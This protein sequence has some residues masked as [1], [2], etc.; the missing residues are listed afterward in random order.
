MGEPAG[1]EEVRRPL[2][3]R[4]RGVGVE[5]VRRGRRV[6]LSFSDGEF[7]LVGAAAGEADLAPGAWA[8]QV[9]V[10]VAKGSLTPAPTDD[11]E[12]FR[13]LAEARVAVNRIG[14]NLNQIAAAVNAAVV[15]GADPGE[16]VTAQQVGVVLARVDAALRRLDAATVAIARR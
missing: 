1:Q 16:A 15:S 4:E 10:A 7:E 2:M 11:R 5:G 8:A 3:R 9:V 6:N 13:A 12:V 14:T